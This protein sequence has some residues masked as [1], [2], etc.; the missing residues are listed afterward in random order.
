MVDSSDIRRLDDCKM[1][2]DNLLKEE[3]LGHC[4]LSHHFETKWKALLMFLDVKEEIIP[5]CFCI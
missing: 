4:Y 2:L 5:L 1:E 3:V